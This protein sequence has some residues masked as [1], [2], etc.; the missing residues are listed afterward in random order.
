MNNTNNF[1]ARASFEKARQFFINAWL[2]NFGGDLQKTADYV[3][4]LKLS[5]NEIRLEVNL[6]T[7][8]TQFKFGLT[9]NQQ[10]TTNVQFLTENRLQMQDSF[11]ANEYGIFVAQTTGNNDAAYNLR[12]YPN[13]QEF[14]AADV[15]AL[16]STFYSNGGF[17]MTCNND[18]IMPYRGL[19]NHLYRPQTQQTA[20]LGAGSPADQIRGS[21]DGMVTLEPNILL[22]G[23]KGYVPEIVL[24]AALAS[25]AANLRCVLVFRG[26]LAQNS[27]SVS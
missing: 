12:T 10:N 16:Q 24:P 1:S 23:S 3:D 8:N 4:G 7:T 15:A 2:G 26:V 14:A 5:Q 6:T 19:F 13:T 20:A 11:V 27:T 17:R 9:P 21:E 25:A 18:V 22:I